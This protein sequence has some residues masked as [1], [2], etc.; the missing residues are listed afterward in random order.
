MGGLVARSACHQAEAAG[1]GWLPK[2]RKLIFLG[3]P[4]LGAPLEKGG[5]QLVRAL[6]LSP[7]SL[8]LSRLAGARSAGIR[9]LRQGTVASDRAPVPLPHGVDCYAAAA[10][11]AQSE[12]RPA[13]RWVGDGL[14]PLHSALGQHRKADRAL[15]FS[16]ARRWTGYGMGHQDLLSHPEVYR[17]LQRWM[18]PDP[19]D[20][21]ST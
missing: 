8:P 3:T 19:A 16:P 20:R 11:L 14:V 21:P 15:G 2:L 9:D 6:G 7:Y 5:H 1:H 17:Q 18:E 4:H 13:A 12:H 10:V